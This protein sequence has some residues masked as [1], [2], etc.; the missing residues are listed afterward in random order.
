[1]DFKRVLYLAIA[2]VSVALANFPA[3]ADVSAQDILN[4]QKTGED[5]VTS[6]M[7]PRGQRY[8][9]LDQID[10]GNVAKL[11]PAWSFTFSGSSD[12]GSSDVKYRP[13]QES[14]PVIR[15]G[16]IYITGS[17]NSIWALDAKSGK[18]IWKYQETLADDLKICCGRVN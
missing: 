4:D 17:G 12:S 9:P 7:G 18:E 1:M 11:V 15:D 14:Q 13:G 2:A 6:G 3:E 10:L 5:V 8:S 16:V